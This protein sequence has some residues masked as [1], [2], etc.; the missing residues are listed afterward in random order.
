MECLHLAELSQKQGFMTAFP[1]PLKYSAW[2]VRPGMEE[3]GALQ[4]EGTAVY[5][6]HCC[7]TIDTRSR[8][9][10]TPGRLQIRPGFGIPEDMVNGAGK[11]GMI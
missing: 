8:G 11:G 7:R 4:A 3:V 5:P 9:S 10:R 6:V 2:A 1:S